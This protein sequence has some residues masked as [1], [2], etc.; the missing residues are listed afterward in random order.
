MSNFGDLWLYSDPEDR[1]KLRPRN[2]RSRVV[3]VYRCEEC[4]APAGESC[5]RK[6]ISGPVERRLPH[7]GRGKPGRN[8]PALSRYFHGEGR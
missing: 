3:A 1:A 5:T 8:D 2:L 7:L 6:T 4:G